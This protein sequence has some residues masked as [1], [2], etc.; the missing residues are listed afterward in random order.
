M[1]EQVDKA[2]E[3]SDD[4]LRRSFTTFRMELDRGMPA[5]PHSE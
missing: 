4:D 5:D 2:A 1:L 3:V